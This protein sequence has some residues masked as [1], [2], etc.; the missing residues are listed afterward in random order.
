M[1]NKAIQVDKTKY[2]LLHTHRRNNYRDIV[3]TYTWLLFWNGFD[4]DNLME[5]PFQP[6]GSA[7]VL[8]CGL[9]G[10]ATSSSESLFGLKK[11]RYFNVLHFLKVTL[12]NKYSDCNYNV[13]LSLDFFRNPQPINCII[14]P[15]RPLLCCSSSVR[16]TSL[17]ATWPPSQVSTSTESWWTWCWSRTGHTHAPGLE[18]LDTWRCVWLVSERI[19]PM[20]Q[21]AHSIAVFHLG[22][23]I[24]TPATD[25][26]MCFNIP[27]LSDWPLH[28]VGRISLELRWLA[29]R[30][31]Q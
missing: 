31:A 10:S 14:S 26:Y 9:R 13:I 17:V 25:F 7:V 23:R 20:N 24:N 27:L 1:S 18:D 16:N 15:W 29:V 2:N 4:K 21:V 8:V 19:T 6:P 30:G 3:L 5:F 28:L 22:E 12:F 11:L